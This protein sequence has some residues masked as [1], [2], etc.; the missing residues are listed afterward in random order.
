[1]GK[2]DGAMQRHNQQA[3][4]EERPAQVAAKKS[5]SRS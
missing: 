2:R 3:K 5:C 4:E 1:M